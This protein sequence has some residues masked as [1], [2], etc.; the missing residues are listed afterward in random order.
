MYADL[1]DDIA[2]E[3]AA[4]LTCRTGEGDHAQVLAFD[5]DASGAIATLGPVVRTSQDIQLILDVAAWPSGGLRVK[6]GDVQVCCGDAAE[7]TQTQWRIYGWDG[8]GYSRIGGP[9]TFPPNR[10]QTDLVLTVGELVL[11]PTEDGRRFGLLTLTVRNSGPV[12]SDAQDIVI[13]LPEGA[14][15]GSGWTGCTPLI[16]SQGRCTH[17]VLDVGQRFTLHLGVIL[18][19]G[20]AID[21]S[22]PLWVNAVNVNSKTGGGR[23]DTNLANNRLMYHV[24]LR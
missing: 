22:R 19:D 9:A 24:R 3:T 17:G 11:A 20:V 14:R 12:R 4:L 8:G 13:D 2:T 10:Y 6:L 16:G 7:N 1:D 5:R 18:D 23:F 21:A 15:A